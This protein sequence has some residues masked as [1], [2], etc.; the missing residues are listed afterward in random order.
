[1]KLVTAS[2]MKE[3]DRLSTEEYA[4]PGSLLMD[5]ASEAVAVSAL[6]KLSGLKGQRVV[7]FAGGGN[8]GGDGFGAARWLMNMGMHVKVFFTGS[9]LD[10]VAGDAKGQLDMYLAAGGKVEQLTIEDDFLLAEIAVRRAD[11]VLDAIIGTGFHGELS[12]IAQRACRLMN[13]CNTP[14]L[15]VDIP[16]GVNADTGACAKD[17]VNARWTVTMAL[18]KTGLL[19]HPGAAKCGRV[20]VAAIGTPSAL[21]DSFN[22]GKY[23]LDAGF[24]SK[25]LPVRAPDA[26]KGDAGRVLIC[27]G[28]PGFTG[29]AALCSY[30]AVK[31]GAGLVSLLT[32]L[33]SREVLA[34]KL[35]EVMVHGLLERMPGVLGGGAVSD[36]LQRSQRAD[37]L[38]IGPGLGLSE[39]TQQGI[40]DII[41]R[42]S[43][44]LVIDADALTAVAA[45]PELLAKLSVPKV[46]TPHAGEMSRL[47]GLTL[48]DINGNRIEVAKKYAQAWKAVL[49][50]KGAPTIVACPDGRIYVN[51]TGS[52]A[53]ASGGS[54]DVLTGIIAGLAGQGISLEAAAA[55]GVYLHGL[56][57]TMA[58][59]GVGLAAGEIAANLPAAREKTLSEASP[60]IYRGML[61]VL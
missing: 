1:M 46:L 16:T 35:T 57:G 34:V 7:V 6:E 30:A 14:V 22:S 15:A 45:A 3:I 26:H 4:V 24:V 27:A 20:E 39:S 48:E 18:P 44:P 31:A 49:V 12:G 2:E 51:S 41:T 54:G 59:P 17:A 23:R 61:K 43:I 28:S 13:T 21:I 42:V 58:C 47:T 33:S 50:L 29:A 56:A 40:R 25:L 9:S 52:S 60:L 32:P 5:S 10:K 36:V 55:A 53:L 11:I 38:A 8:N 37:V 19:L